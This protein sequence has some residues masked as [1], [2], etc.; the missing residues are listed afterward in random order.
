MQTPVGVS[1]S[2]LAKVAA[3]GKFEPSLLVLAEILSERFINLDMFTPGKIL[4]IS[5]RSGLISGE[6]LKFVLPIC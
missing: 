6:K 4:S 5:G 2:V 1:R 3:F